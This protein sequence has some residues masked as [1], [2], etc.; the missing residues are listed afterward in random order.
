MEIEVAKPPGTRPTGVARLPNDSLVLTASSGW[1]R[2]FLIVGVN[3]MKGFFAAVL[4]VAWVPAVSAQVCTEQATI[5]QFEISFEGANYDGSDT[6]F[7]YC[8]TTLDDPAL[9]HW[10]L[11]FDTACIDA[12]NLTGCGPEP[13]DYQVDD[14]TTG[15][16]GIKWDDLELDPGE[17][18]CYTF[19]LEGDWT[20]QLGDTPVA[21]KAGQGVH[22]GDICGPICFTCGASLAVTAEPGARAEYSLR[23]EHRRP[24]SVESKVYYLVSDERGRRVK[25][26]QTD[27]FIL[28]Y[29]DVFEFGGEIPTRKPLRS[30]SYTLLIRMRGM[31]KWIERQTTFVIE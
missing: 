23:L 27:D 21:F 2:V 7:E 31:S 4:L 14:P 13:C 22:Y 17:T 12:N 18:E 10:D 29:G 28:N 9:S 19:K 16:T 8:V 5:G 25:K 24:V 11:E 6:E 3:V 15:I 20:G 30:G 1:A 26:W